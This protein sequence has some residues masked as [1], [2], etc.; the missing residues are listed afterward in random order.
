MA[1]ALEH[2][3][4]LLALAGTPDMRE[5]E[6]RVAAGDAEAQSALEVYLHRLVIGIGAMTA[7]AGGLV[8]V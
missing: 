3:S 1:R 7:A 6:T 4:G 8:P 2:E 5:V